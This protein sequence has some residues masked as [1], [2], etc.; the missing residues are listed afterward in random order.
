MK[1]VMK[2]IPL[3]LCV[4]C[5]AGMIVGWQQNTTAIWFVALGGWANAAFDQL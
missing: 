3:A 2:Y 5:V 4:V 1:Q